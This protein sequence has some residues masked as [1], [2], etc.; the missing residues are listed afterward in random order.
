MVLVQHAIPKKATGPDGIPCRILK[1]AAETLS[2]SLAM[3]FNQ[4]LSMG[5]Y[6]DDWKMARVTPIFKDGGKENLSNYRPISRR[7]LVGLFA[8]NF[9]HIDLNTNDLINPYQSGFRTT[10]S[11]LTSLLESTSD[12]CVNIDKSL[13]NGSGCNL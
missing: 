7:F 5:V 3:L 12:W 2:P 1:I 8:I 10:Y 11:T 6:P 13:L 9:T 4:S